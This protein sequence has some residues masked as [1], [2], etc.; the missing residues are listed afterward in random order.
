MILFILAYWEKPVIMRSILL[1]FSVVA[2]LSALWPRAI[3]PP[4][5]SVTT[6]T[7]TWQLKPCADIAIFFRKSRSKTVTNIRLYDFLNRENKQSAIIDNKMA[8]F[9]TQNCMNFCMNFVIKSMNFVKPH[10]Y[11][12]WCW[13]VIFSTVTDWPDWVSLEREIIRRIIIWHITEKCHVFYLN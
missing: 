1:V 5:P 3:H 10:L 11:K 8:E 7:S 9:Q 12:I 4:Y 2:V 6:S 13:Y